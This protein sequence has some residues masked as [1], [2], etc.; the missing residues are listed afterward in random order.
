MRAMLLKQPRPIEQRPLSYIELPDPEPG[1]R[2]IRIKV[3]A[4]G[5]CHT[6][7][8]EVEGEL[9]A[10]GLPR[11]IGHEIVG[12]VD[13]LGTGASRFKLAQRV[14]VPWLYRTCGKCEFCLA[15]KENLCDNSKFTG[16]DV[17]GGYAELMIVDEDFAYPIP[18]RFSD[19]NAAPLL[20]AGVIGLRALRLSEV[21]PGQRLGLFGFGASAHVAIQVA[22]HWG[23]EVYVFS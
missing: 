21:K 10:P 9:V 15:G 12:K 14:G 17:D 1:A 16:Y 2:Q 6:D 3:L 8:H 11:V 22:V 13:K 4:C 23:C 18:E 7:L 20:C 19:A 5:V